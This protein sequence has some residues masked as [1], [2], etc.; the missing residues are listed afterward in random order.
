MKRVKLLVIEPVGD[1]DLGHM[2]ADIH[3]GMRYD[4]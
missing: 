3:E 4:G 1:G 2:T